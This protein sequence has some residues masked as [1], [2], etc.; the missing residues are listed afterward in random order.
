MLPGRMPATVMA[1]A[2][3]LCGTLVCRDDG[4]KM[5]RQ[6]GIL[7]QHTAHPHTPI[8]AKLR[9]AAAASVSRALLP[10]FNAA[11]AAAALAVKRADNLRQITVISSRHSPSAS[12]W[13]WADQRRGMHNK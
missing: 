12:G 13:D 7:A 8:S 11:A 5:F 3:A 10:P 9:I 6:S 1:A 2:A 4:T